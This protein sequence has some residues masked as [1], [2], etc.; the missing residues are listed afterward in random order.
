M[1]SGETAHVGR[2]PTRPASAACGVVGVGRGRGQAWA[3]LRMAGPW[4]APSSLERMEPGRS[5]P[6]SAQGQ[7][8]ATGTR[9]RADP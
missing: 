5:G 8:S 6:L 2:A 7:L 9:S 1:P 4:P 3:D